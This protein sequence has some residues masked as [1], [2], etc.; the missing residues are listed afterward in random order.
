MKSIDETN[1]S[2]LDS[3]LS[4]ELSKLQAI[5]NTND[6]LLAICVVNTVPGVLA[7]LGNGLILVIIPKFYALQTVFNILIFSLVLIDI[8][9]G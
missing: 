1:T 4:Q 5:T 9:V 6:Y 2:C 3:T 8:L 7:I